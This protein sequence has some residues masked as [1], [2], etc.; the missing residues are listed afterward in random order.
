MF[1]DF[2][3]TIIANGTACEKFGMTLKD[4]PFRQHVKYM[5]NWGN[6]GKSVYA[7]IGA[8]PDTASPNI[9]HTWLRHA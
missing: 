1:A 5:Y 8:T 6:F 4:V 9:S 7:P 3:I 2:F